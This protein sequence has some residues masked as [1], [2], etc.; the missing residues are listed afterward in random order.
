MTTLFAPTDEQQA[1]IGAELVAQRVIACAGSGKTATIVR[2]LA[3]V[4]RRLGHSRQHVALLSFSNVAVDTFREEYVRL[5]A[6]MP[7]L[8]SRVLIST[9]DAFVTSHLIAPHA[10][11]V[12]ACDR[13]PFL[14]QGHEPFLSGFKVFNG[15]FNSDIG[16]LRVSISDAGSWAFEIASMYGSTS[17][18]SAAATSVIRRLGKAGAYTYEIGRYWAMCAL[19]GNPRLE[20]I[21]AHRYPYILVDEA[22][23]IG[24]VHGALLLRLMRAG[25]KVSLIGDPNQAIYEFANADGSFL[26]GFDP[27]E[28]G[29]RHTLSVNQRSLKAIVDVANAL[30]D[31]EVTTPRLPP[32]RRHGAFFVQYDEAE[33][34][35]LLEM[36]AQLLATH[37]YAPTEAAILCRARETLQRLNGSSSESGQGATEL[38]ARAAIHRDQHADMAMAFE[39]A[40]DGVLKLTEGS[41]PAL[42]AAVLS[43]SSQATAKALRREVWTFVKSSEAGLP[44]AKLPAKAEW[45]PALKRNVEQLLARLPSCCGLNGLP[46]WASNLTIKKLP[47][48]PLWDEQLIAISSARPAIKTVHQAKGESIGAVLYVLKPREVKQVLAGPRNEEGRIGYV[49]LTRAKDLLIVAIPNSTQAAVVE[50]IRSTG[51]QPWA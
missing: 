14:V 25:S 11:T 34:P 44:S 33:M 49:G 22:Q 8:S 19:D 38:F 10:G 4:R 6:E 27:G 21:L 29:Q 42:R 37:G 32:A 18:P 48:R 36:F 28:T 1:I 15:K 17:I 31:L 35:K 46:T 26:K 50:Q 45:Q 51:L 9:M 43:S 39:F 2:R 23:D 24:V 5:T 40:L 16:S 12:M 7:G 13:Q 30:C 3:E 41:P 47:E 20:E